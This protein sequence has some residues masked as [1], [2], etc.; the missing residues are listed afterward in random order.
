MSIVGI[1]I[2]NQFIKIAALKNGAVETLLFNQSS[3]KA[4]TLLCYQ[5][6]RYLGLDAV[7]M[8]RNYLP[9]SIGYLKNLI[10]EFY[11]KQKNVNNMFASVNEDEKVIQ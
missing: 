9:N 6:K 2:G 4:P 10:I 5:D 7:N 11:N 1:D 3:R 8:V